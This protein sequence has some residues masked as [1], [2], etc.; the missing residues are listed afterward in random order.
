M[1][2]RPSYPTQNLQCEFLSYANR[3]YGEL[4]PELVFD[5]AGYANPDLLEGLEPQTSFGRM[6]AT[7][8]FGAYI[9]GKGKMLPV[10]L[11]PESLNKA[12]LGVDDLDLIVPHQVE[13]FFNDLWIAEAEKIGIRPE[14]WRDTWDKY[15]NVAGVDVPITLAELSEAGEIPADAVVSLF[16]P[17]ASGHS[18]TLLVKWLAGERIK[19]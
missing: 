4:Y 1:P 2:L 9:Y 6:R 14:L 13:K 7:D 16:S 10:E 18:P 11:I 5:A 12:G 19:Q 3:T 15:G 17:G 8:G